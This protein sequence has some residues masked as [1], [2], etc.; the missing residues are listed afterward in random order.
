MTKC[1]GCNIQD[2]RVVIGPSIGVCCY[3]VEV[4]VE[5]LFSNSSLLRQCVK[6]VEGKCKRHLDLQNC[7]RL[8]LVDAGIS[9]EHIDD[10]PN[11]LCT[12][13]NADM[14]FSY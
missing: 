1:F 13:C 12:Y 8:Q 3:E 4:D 5:K 2:V 14:F 11:K 7:V 10:S 6:V 9:T